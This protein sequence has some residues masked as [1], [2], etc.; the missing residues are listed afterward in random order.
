MC[1]GWSEVEGTVYLFDAVTGVLNP[2]WRKE[3]GKIC[4]YIDGEKQT[5]ELEIAGEHYYFSPNPDNYGEMAV[6]WTSY[7]GNEYYFDDEGHRVSGWYKIGETEYYFGETSGICEKG[8][9]RENNK[10]YYYL[11][12]GE[13]YHGEKKIDGKWYYFDPNKDG[14][15]ATGWYDVPEKSGGMKHVY[16][17]SDGSICYGEKKIDG[18]WY[19]FNTTTGEMTVGWCDVP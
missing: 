18:K 4:Y 12:S 8:F 9:V 11:D 17:D 16:Y 5:G 7:G 3:N 19:Y 13:K 1:H 6:G 14:E 15:M 2:G 10:A